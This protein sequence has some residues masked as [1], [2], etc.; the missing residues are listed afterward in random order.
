MNHLMPAGLVR[1][2]D[3]LVD[4]WPAMAFEGVVQ[5]FVYALLA[6]AC[7]RA[8]GRVDVGQVA[9]FSLG[10]FAAYAV[11]WL[12]GFRPGPTP[13]VAAALVPVHL[14]V[15]LAA[16][17][18]VAT[19]VSAAV[20]FRWS[21][22]LGVGVV[23]VVQLGLW[24]LRGPTA[25]PQIRVFRPRELLPGVDSV[26]VT[27]VVLAAA[28]IAGSIAATRRGVPP[29]V[30]SGV[31]SG[32]AALLYLVKVPGA[33][34]Y[35]TG[36][37]VGL[38]AVTAALLGRTPR[39]VVVAAILLGLLELLFETVVGPRWWLPF[40]AFLLVAALGFRLL[41]ARRRRRRAVAD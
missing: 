38:Y 8:A 25:E 18:V 16:A 34:W 27:V 31:L 15:A 22:P 21:A 6:L 3:L 10:V 14:G 7:T 11:F 26:Q 29:V 2:A 1:G 23:A 5:G 9:G 30:V 17:V 24:L 33:A 4:Q 20:G 35:L 13:D 40:A 12:L 36:I 41:L 37:S 39:G 19:A 32:L 28:A